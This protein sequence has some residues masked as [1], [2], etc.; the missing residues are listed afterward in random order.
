MYAIYA[1]YFYETSATPG[2]LTLDLRYKICAVFSSSQKQ[3]KTKLNKQ[4]LQMKI[5]SIAPIV[6]CADQA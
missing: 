1:N 3:N 2:S 5:K 6:H 4:A